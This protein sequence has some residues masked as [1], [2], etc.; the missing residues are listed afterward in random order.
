MSVQ[1]I[2]TRLN[3]TVLGGVKIIAYSDM[4]HAS[5]IIDV[6]G[7]NAFGDLAK[8]LRNVR[9]LMGGC[10]RYDLAVKSA[11]NDFISQGN[12]PGVQNILV[13][14]VS[15]KIPPYAVSSLKSTSA[16]LK[17]SKIPTFAVGIGSAVE[18]KDLEIIATEPTKVF[19]FERF[20]NLQ[21]DKIYKDICKSAGE[22]SNR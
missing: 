11:Y 19:I 10:S 7:K 17:Q 12:R 8:R 9:Y 15:R 6:H 20:D 14:F 4:V 16:L 22:A 18:S 13:L 3:V 2:A 1:R 5:Q 21:W